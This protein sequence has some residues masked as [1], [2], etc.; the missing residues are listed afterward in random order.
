WSLR[1][2]DGAS[3]AAIQR[4]TNARVAGIDGL[5]HRRGER[6]RHRGASRPA[7]TNPLGSGA[8]CGAPRRYARSWRSLRSPA[9]GRLSP[10]P[11]LGGV[12]LLSGTILRI[13]SPAVAE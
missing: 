9:A 8:E 3:L 4:Q 2:G 7:W 13:S 11:R 6:H 1:E 12:G 10:L 5:E